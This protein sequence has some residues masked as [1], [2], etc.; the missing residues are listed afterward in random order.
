M[1]WQ[2][3]HSRKGEISGALRD[4]SLP[5]RSPILARESSLGEEGRPAAPVPA[6]PPALHRRLCPALRSAG[7]KTVR[8]GHHGITSS[9]TGSLGGLGERSP[10]SE[11]VSSS[12]RWE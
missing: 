1:G 10:C 4:P 9:I 3:P 11:P 8:T 5:R 2:R 6:F 7:R 12:I